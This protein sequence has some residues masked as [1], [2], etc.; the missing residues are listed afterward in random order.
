[1][2][3]FAFVVLA[4]MGLGALLFGGARS[5]A[6]GVGFLALIPIFL[7]LKLVFIAMIFG[8]FA[9]RRHGYQWRSEDSR[10][11]WMRG[12]SQRRRSGTAARD[13]GPSEADRFEEWHNMAHAKEEVDSWVPETE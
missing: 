10:P 2:F 13:R 5:A 6:V 3:R 4:A 11:P 1:M 12:G 7:F 9:R 8:V